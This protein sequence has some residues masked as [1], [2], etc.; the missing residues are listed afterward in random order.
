MCTSTHNTTTPLDGIN[1]AAQG[2]VFAVSPAAERNRPGNEQNE[3]IS[4]GD[5][6]FFFSI[7]VF[8][9]SVAQHR[10]RNLYTMRVLCVRATGIAVEKY[11]GKKQPH[12]CR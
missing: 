10:R 12:G 9:P 3:L 8:F 6:F 11:R 7:F 2:T 1:S 5:Y 4:G